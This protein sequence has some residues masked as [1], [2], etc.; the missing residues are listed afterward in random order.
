MQGNQEQFI[1]TSGRNKC[2]SATFSLLK[3]H[4]L[5]LKE[6]WNAG[7]NWKVNHFEIA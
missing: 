6:V 7:T 2:L 4:N 5:K 1:L 3:I